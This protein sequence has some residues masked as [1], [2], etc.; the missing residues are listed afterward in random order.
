MEIMCISRETTDKKYR[1]MCKKKVGHFPLCCF[2]LFFLSSPAPL[3]N[4][5]IKLPGKCLRT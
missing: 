5:A 3:C 4:I 1:D 2:F